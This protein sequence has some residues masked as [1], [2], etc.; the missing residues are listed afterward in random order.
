MENNTNLANR[1]K[2]FIDY[3][4]ISINKF[5]ISVG[6]SNSYFNKVLKDNNSIGSDRIEKILRTYPDLSPEWLLTGSGKMIKENDLYK[7]DKMLHKS[8]S[9]EYHSSN[10]IP[11]YDLEATAGVLEVFNNNHQN[12]PIDH[13]TIPNLPKCDG[14]LYIRGDS[15]Y[16]LLKS[17]DIVAYKI[18]QDRHNIIWGEM[19]LIYISHNGDEYFFCKFLKKSSKEGYAELISHNQHHQSVEFPLES[20]QALAMVKAS[21]RFNTLI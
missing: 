20:I 15:M 17:G 9:T 13:I 12:I 4:D 1:I 7:V 10:T 11:L 16:P 18:I 5:S 14:A 8:K 19:Y 21:I 3:K 6:A 2:Q